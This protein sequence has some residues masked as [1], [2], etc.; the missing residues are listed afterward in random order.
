MLNVF[1]G[2]GFGKKAKGKGKEKFRRDLHM[3]MHGGPGRMGS[4]GLPG[5]IVFR[6]RMGDQEMDGR[7][8]GDPNVSDPCAEKV[9]I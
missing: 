2:G 3:E 5:G 1:G 8:S 6:D 7:E 9:E 4:N